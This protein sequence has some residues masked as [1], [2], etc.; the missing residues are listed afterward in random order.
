MN[1]APTLAST[2][3]AVLT[4][5]NKYI[6]SKGLPPDDVVGKMEPGDRYV[7]EYHTGKP[8]LAIQDGIGIMEASQEQYDE[9]IDAIAKGQFSITA[10]DRFGEVSAVLHKATGNPLQPEKIR[11]EYDSGGLTF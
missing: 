10:Y 6:T 4:A 11:R 5:W 3:E 7:W 1:K 8:T 9:V 2:P